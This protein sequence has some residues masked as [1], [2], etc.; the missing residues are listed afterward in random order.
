MNVKTGIQVAILVA[1]QVTEQVLAQ[2]PEGLFVQ[3]V[4]PV[5][6]PAGETPAKVLAAEGVV[7]VVQGGLAIKYAESAGRWA[8]DSVVLTPSMNRFDGRRSICVVDGTVLRQLNEGESWQP[9]WSFSLGINYPSWNLLGA[10]LTSTS[11]VYAY[12]GGQDFYNWAVRPI[13]GG[14]PAFFSGEPEGNVLFVSS[15]SVFG[16]ARIANGFGRFAGIGPT[17]VLSFFDADLSDSLAV[18]IFRTP[19]A[20]SVVLASTLGGSPGDYSVSAS[21]R[22]FAPARCAAG[23][24]SVFALGNI[25]GESVSG[26][27][28]EFR[29]AAGGGVE[30]VGEIHL[31]ANGPIG[32]DGNDLVAATRWS[33]SVQGQ[34]ELLIIRRR[35]SVDCDQDGIDDCTAVSGDLVADINGNA[36]PDSCECIADLF[37]DRQVNG[38][39]LGALLSQWGPASAGTVSDVNRD[40]NVDGADLGYLLANWGPCPN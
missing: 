3:Q 11:V 10:R 37:V 23:T 39:D 14:D 7:W 18:A 36:I 19:P 38:A 30:A 27:I 13:T 31:G 12:S 25:A 8:Q 32:A 17:P 33:A 35:V 24:S 2:C 1:V 16:V 40:G 21:G 15:N 29:A 22:P 20:D 26:S 9:W 4:V 34:R 28:V 5:V 6:A